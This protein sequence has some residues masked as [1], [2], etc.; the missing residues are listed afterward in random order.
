MKISIVAVFA[1]SSLNKLMHAADVFES[2]KQLGEFYTL[3]ITGEPDLDFLCENM[4]KTLE[5]SGKSVTFASIVKVDGVPTNKYPYYLK[6]GVASISN[7]HQWALFK[8]LLNQRGFDVET[9]NT[10][11]VKSATLIL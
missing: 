1:E 9:D 5:E 3:E 4:R 8:D 11:K 2:F 7:G 6:P 10:M